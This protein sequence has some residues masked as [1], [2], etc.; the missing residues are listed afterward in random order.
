VQDWY[1]LLLVVLLLWWFFTLVAPI[2]SVVAV[3]PR[4]S[5]GGVD[6]GQGVKKKKL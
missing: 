5:V 3:V 2:C 1:L 6:C 4:G